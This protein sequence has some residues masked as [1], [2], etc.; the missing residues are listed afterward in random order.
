MSWIRILKLE[1]QVPEALEEEEEVFFDA[2]QKGLKHYFSATVLSNEYDI[3]WEDDEELLKR[4]YCL[5]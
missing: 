1:Y 4:L 2:C 3:E 5:K